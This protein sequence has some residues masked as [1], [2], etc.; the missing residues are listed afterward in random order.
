M[1]AVGAPEPVDSFLEGTASVVT[2]VHR[3]VLPSFRS[4]DALDVERSSF[5]HAPTMDI[6]D[7]N[8]KECLGKWGFRAPRFPGV[9]AIVCALHVAV[10]A[11]Y[12]AFRHFKRKT[13]NRVVHHCQIELFGAAPRDMVELHYIG[14]VLYSAVRTRTRLCLSDHRALNCLSSRSPI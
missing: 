4:T 10:G 3:P 11:H 2:P 7:R 12:V 6:F 13:L 8:V 14:R 9:W 5:G 1:I